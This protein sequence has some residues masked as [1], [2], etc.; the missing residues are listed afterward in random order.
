MKFDLKSLVFGIIIG[1]LSTIIIGAL[2][3]DV[4][5]D[6][7]IGDDSEYNNIKKDD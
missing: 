3:S 1:I 7:R 4:Y 2:L 6:I 5:V